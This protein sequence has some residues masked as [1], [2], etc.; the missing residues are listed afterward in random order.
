MGKQTECRNGC[1]RI[2]EW[3]NN[4][5]GKYKFVEAAT[6]QLHNCPNY[7]SAKFEQ[8]KQQGYRGPDQNQVQT[9]VANLVG[10]V[11]V[12]KEQVKELQFTL[13][14]ISKTLAAM[15]FKPASEVE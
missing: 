11:A 8:N 9:D 4:Q 13:N 15:S 6:G 1:G 14:G 10:D 7:K 2:L 3:D 12:L 5:P